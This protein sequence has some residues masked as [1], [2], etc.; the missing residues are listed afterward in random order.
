MTAKETS[1]ETACYLLVGCLCPVFY[2]YS[3]NTIETLEVLDN[4]DKID[5]ELVMALIHHIVRYEEVSLNLGVW[6]QGR[7]NSS[8]WNKIFNI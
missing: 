6:F 8:V 5:L 1:K 4:D 7:Q 2:R 3:D